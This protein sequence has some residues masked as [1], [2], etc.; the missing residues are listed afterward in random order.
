M[1]GGLPPP[2]LGKKVNVAIFGDQMT[3]HPPEPV[4]PTQAVE[5]ILTGIQRSY[6]ILQT[7]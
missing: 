7:K 3:P 1:R 5:T 6:D 2:S 4:T